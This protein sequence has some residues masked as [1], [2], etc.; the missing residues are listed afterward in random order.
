MHKILAAR[1]YYIKGAMA[2]AVAITVALAIFGTPH[3]KA[4]APM[5]AGATLNID[6][7]GANAHVISIKHDSFEFGPMLPGGACGNEEAH[8]LWLLVPKTLSV[9]S[10]LP[11]VAAT[12]FT[13]FKVY[14]LTG[15]T[16]S[17]DVADKNKPEL[18]A[19]A[20][21]GTSNQLTL[22][23]DISQFVSDPRLD[24]AWRKKLSARFVLRGGIVS[25]EPPSDPPAG[26][27]IWEFK[28][29][30]HPSTGVAQNISDHLKYS[31]SLATNEVALKFDDGKK[32]TVGGALINLTLLTAT[33]TSVMKAPSG[34]TYKIGE[35]AHEYCRFYDVLMSPPSANDRPIPVLKSVE[36][37]Q[38]K[39]HAPRPGKYCGGAR[40]LEL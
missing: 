35:G 8:Q 40:F 13:T 31:R 6:I 25:V 11:A 32:I 10:D 37:K 34:A 24:P 12:Q 39:P 3:I 2:L 30:D 36:I 14:R 27:A 33:A 4:I 29:H 7:E 21:P 9:T 15:L 28:A 19:L 1:R 22:V 26:K 17:L 5:A 16:G 38:G 20:A 23:P 18:P